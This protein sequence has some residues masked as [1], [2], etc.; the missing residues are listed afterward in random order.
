VPVVCGIVGHA[1]KQERCV[2]VLW[3]ASDDPSTA[4]TTRPGWRCRASRPHRVGIPVLELVAC[5]SEQGRDDGVVPW[6]SST[7][8]F[9]QR[10]EETLC[11][12]TAAAAGDDGGGQEEG[13]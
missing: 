3:R 4:A 11:A 10:F 7:E 6:P 1:G 13:S 5:S 2:E 12:A 8:E 9:E